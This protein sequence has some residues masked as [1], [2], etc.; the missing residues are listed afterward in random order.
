MSELV[1]MS[2]SIERPLFRKL[3]KMVAKSR[4][5]NRSEFLRDLIREHLV[6]EEWDRNAESIG[7]I[8]LIYD[9]H[10]RGPPSAPADDGLRLECKQ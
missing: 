3:E 7:T 6:D 5:G 10:A 1:R 8:T 2:M 4:Y 9:H